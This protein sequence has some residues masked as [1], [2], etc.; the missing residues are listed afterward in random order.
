MG[1]RGAICMP[2]TLPPTTLPPT[3]YGLLLF[4]LEFEFV[5]GDNLGLLVLETGGE[6]G[7]CCC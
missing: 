4:A 6:E 1:D 2:P 7:R 3:R 5:V